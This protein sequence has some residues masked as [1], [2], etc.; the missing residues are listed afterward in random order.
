MEHT[1]TYELVKDFTAPAV[2][3]FGVGITGAIAFIC[4]KIEERRIE[5]AL[6]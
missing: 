2:A 1:Y 6:A 5:V 4:E 3:V